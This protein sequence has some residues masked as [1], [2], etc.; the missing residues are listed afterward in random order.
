M[1]KRQKALDW[2]AKL[3]TERRK[4]VVSVTVL[5]TLAFVS[6]IPKL[7]A[8]PAPESLLS[9]FEGEEYA[10]IQRRFEEW[11]GERRTA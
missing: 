7:T 5:I 11:F 9:S 4:L 3:V 6:Q 8:D 1:S 10:A 2:L